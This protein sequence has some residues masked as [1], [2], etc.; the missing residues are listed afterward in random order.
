MPPPTVTITRDAGRL[1]V[2]APYNPQFVAFA[3]LVGGRYVNRKWEFEFRAENVVR[4]R[5]D[6]LYNDSV[7]TI[8]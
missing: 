4:E 2:E 6:D 8:E 5:I 3:K 1:M 7:L